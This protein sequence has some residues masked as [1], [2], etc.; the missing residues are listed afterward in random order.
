MRLSLQLC[1]QNSDAAVPINYQYPLSAAIYKILAQAS[2]D[3]ASFLH[4][5]G[6]AS[7]SGRLMKLFTF[8]KLW[9]PGVKMQGT[10]LK[11]IRRSPWR[12]Q[13]ASPMQEEFVQNFVLGL[14]ETAELVLAGQ[15]VRA[16]FRVEQ[17]EALPSPDFKEKQRFK[18]LSPIVAS[19]SHERDGRKHIY[20]YRPHDAGLSEAL[21][22]NLRQKHEIIHGKQPEFVPL[23]FRLEPQDKPKSKLI[24]I[25]EGTSEATHVSCF[26]TYFTLQG[27]VE[28]MQTAWECGLGEHNSQ[29]FGMV[30]VV[31]L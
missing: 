15:G 23:T 7:P 24:T 10:V 27:S 22:K 3:Y 20:Y 21:L 18:C 19:T 31:N 26:E 6:Y 2:P 4:D 5:Q 11:S 28:L 17:V 8:S 30:E 12:V 13:I 14:F 9:I 1:P 29:G 25:K 16:K